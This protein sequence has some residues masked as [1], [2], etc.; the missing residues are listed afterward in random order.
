[1]SE[2]KTEM[3]EPHM[4][5]CD[6]RDHGPDEEFDW[7]CVHVIEWTDTTG[8]PSRAWIRGVHSDH[9][10][11]EVDEGLGLYE[12]ADVDHLVEALAELRPLL[13]EARPLADCLGC[14]ACDE[15]EE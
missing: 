14:P 3:K 10:Y 15:D 9:V 12:P 8:E 5:F 4:P 1:M 11:V 13:A 7:D 6:G 2:K